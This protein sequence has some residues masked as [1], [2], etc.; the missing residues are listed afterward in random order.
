MIKN[1]ANL[2]FR[3]FKSPEVCQFLIKIG[4]LGGASG[5][6]PPLFCGGAAGEAHRDH[7]AS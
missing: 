2:N 6:K 3:R 5:K 7:Q 1:E 4:I